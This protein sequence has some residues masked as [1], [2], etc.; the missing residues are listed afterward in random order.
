MA[1]VPSGLFDMGDEHDIATYKEQP[2]HVVYISSF[3]VDCYGV[4]NGQMVEMLQWALGHGK[5]SASTSTVRNTE[6]DEQELVDLDGEGCRIQWIG[7][8]LRMFIV[9]GEYRSHPCTHVTWYGALAY[10][11][12][13]SD[14]RSQDRCVDFSN[15]TCDFSRNGYRLPTEAEWE[16]AARGGLVG[17]YYPW[18]SQGGS[19]EDHIDGGKANYSGSGDPYEGNQ[20]ATTPVGYFDG[21]Q[22]PP[23]ADMANGFG[24]YDMAGNVQEWCWDRYSSLWYSEPEASSPD[25]TGPTEGAHRAIR[26]GSWGWSPYELRCASRFPQGPSAGSRHVGFRCVRRP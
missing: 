18:S 4:T 25:T 17:H 26:G 21:N 11:N 13:R 10:C 7:S 20:V 6:G 12:Y 9:G 24:L 8:P 16:K 15:W 22:A 19:Y 1:T 14:V 2:A 3:Q 5:V 23:G